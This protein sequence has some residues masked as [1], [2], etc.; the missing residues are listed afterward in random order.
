MKMRRRHLV[1]NHDQSDIPTSRNT[2]LRNTWDNYPTVL[3]VTDKLI[4]TSVIFI[5]VV[6]L[7][8]FF[9]LSLMLFLLLVTATFKQP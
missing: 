6:V 2:N 3:I 7:L 5:L 1:C 4:S 8:L 9:W